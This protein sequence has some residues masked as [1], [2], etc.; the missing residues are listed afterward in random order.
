MFESTSD[1]VSKYSLSNGACCA[2]VPVQEPYTYG[3]PEISGLM[4]LLLHGFSMEEAAIGSM[5]TDTYGG[6]STEV[7]GDPFYTPFVRL[8][9]KRGGGSASGGRQGH[10]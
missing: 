7:W 3:L 8:R 6:R 2:V 10:G 4:W 5:T 1:G 9:V